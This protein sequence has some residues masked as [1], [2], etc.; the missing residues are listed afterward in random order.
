MI[1]KPDG[2]PKCRDYGF[3]DAYRIRYLGQL[4]QQNQELV[5]AMPAYRVHFAYR[6]DDALCS[7]LQDFVAN[8]VPKRVVDVF[9]IVDVQKQHRNASAMAPRTSDRRG[10]SIEQ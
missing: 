4:G 6:R 9:E 3:G 10:E 1:A 2:H 8:P 7:H 5:A